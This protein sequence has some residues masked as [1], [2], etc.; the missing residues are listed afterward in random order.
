MNTMDSDVDNL[1]SDVETELGQTVDRVNVLLKQ[2]DDLNTEISPAPPGT[3]PRARRTAGPPRCRSWSGLMKV[4]VRNQPDGRVYIESS[5]G[6]VLL[7]K[8][9]RQLDYP[10]GRAPP[11]P[12][13]DNDLGIRFAN[14]DGSLGASTG[15][16]IDSS[17]IGG[18]L[19]GL[20]DLRDRALLQFTEQLGQL[21]SGLADSLNK[22]SNE[23][24]RVPLAPAAG[25]PPQRP[26]RRRPAWASPASPPS[27]CSGRTA[28]WSTRSTSISDALDAANP[29]GATIQ[30]AID[31]INAGLGTDATASDRSHHR[32]AITIAATDPDTGVAIAQNDTLAANPNA[33]SRG[34]MGFSQFFGM[35]DVVRSDASP[36]VPS[37]LTP[38][39][40]NGMT[41]TTGPRAA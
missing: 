13:Y 2:I 6:Q 41:G 23:S 26:H 19:G 36:L 14:A 34:G 17:A 10:S 20:I 7:D 32:R 38:T 15:E 25:R 39:D 16:K 21:F 18:K 12:I 11:Q 29:P 37:G 33:S 1:R 4:N 9:L 28:R 24:T 30:D 5:S 31:A 27:P 40:P 3:A 8:R 35:N 22:V